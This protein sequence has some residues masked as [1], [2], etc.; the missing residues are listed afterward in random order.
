[1]ASGCATAF[2]CGNGALCES[3]DAIIYNGGPPR[4]Q[5][6]ATDDTEYAEGEYQNA[7]RKSIEICVICIIGGP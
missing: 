6:E 7:G 2:A 5:N 4:P 3:P 1:M